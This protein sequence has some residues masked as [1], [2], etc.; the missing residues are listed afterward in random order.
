MLRINAAADALV[1][2]PSAVSHTVN[3]L[4]EDLSVALFD[5]SKRK[6]ELTPRWKNVY[7]LAFII[8]ITFCLSFRSTC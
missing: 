1:R 5:R 7:R 3:K 2:V 6:A 4:E 8:K